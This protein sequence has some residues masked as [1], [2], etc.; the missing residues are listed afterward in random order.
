MVVNNG[1]YVQRGQ[2][3]QPL[4]SILGSAAASGFTN[5]PLDGDSFLPFAIGRI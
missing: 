1:A 4:A 5:L 2:A 3:V